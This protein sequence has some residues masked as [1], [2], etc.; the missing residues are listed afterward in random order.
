MNR[1]VIAIGEIP[2]AVLKLK[3]PEHFHITCGTMCEFSESDT[4]ETSDLPSPI[5]PTKES[6][7]IPLPREVIC[8]D[9]PDD[10]K[11]SKYP[12]HPNVTW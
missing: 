11:E 4:S 2:R 3:A 1:K 8:T 10:A 6:S 7:K 5:T 9:L 12:T